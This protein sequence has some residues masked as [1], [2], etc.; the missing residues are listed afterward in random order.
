MGQGVAAVVQEAPS[1]SSGGCSM[2]RPEPP[3]DMC[4]K[5]VPGAGVA[6]KIESQVFDVQPEY[7][8][9]DYYPDCR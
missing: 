1:S 8:V 9:K 7:S 3:G 2:Q 5:S 4:H 6:S